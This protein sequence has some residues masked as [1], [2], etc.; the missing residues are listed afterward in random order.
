M[1]T[2]ALFAVVALAALALPG[3]LIAYEEDSDTWR[4]QG[5]IDSDCCEECLR[6]AVLEHQV[7]AMERHMA[8]DC[9]A[10]CSYCQHAP[11]A[12]AR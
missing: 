1:R 11:A 3:C 2:R 12:E 9:G 4:S 10:D 8:H 6:M 5:L 7:K